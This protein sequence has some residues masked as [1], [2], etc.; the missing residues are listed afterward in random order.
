[1]VLP[2]ATLGWILVQLGGRE[3]IVGP[4]PAAPHAPN[5]YSVD[6]WLGQRVLERGGELS[7]SLTRLH[8]VAA[9]QAFD[10]LRLREHFGVGAGEPWRV[11]MRWDGAVDG[12]AELA[13]T[14]L[15]IDDGRGTLLTPAATSRP[16]KAS[17]LADPLAVRFGAPSALRAGQ[18]LSFVLWGREPAEFAVLRGF[19]EELKLRRDSYRAPARGSLLDSL[20]RIDSQGATVDRVGSMNGDTDGR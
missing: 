3:R 10:A 8:G 17:E 15:C 20:A 2:M 12:A 11:E 5:A 13:L 18:I 1:M 9:T 14:D 16:V 6:A 7:V 19:G 4:A